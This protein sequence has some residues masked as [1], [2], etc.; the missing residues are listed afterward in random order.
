MPR[1]NYNKELKQLRAEFK[2]IFNCEL[3]YHLFY[4]ALKNTILIDYPWTKSIFEKPRENLEERF[5]YNGHNGEIRWLMDNL[6]D[7]FN[8]DIT[9]ISRFMQL[10]KLPL[11]DFFQL[12]IDGYEYADLK[13]HESFIDFLS[14]LE[15]PYSPENNDFSYLFKDN[16]KYAFD[17]FHNIFDR[18]I[19]EGLVLALDKESG[20]VFTGY[21][22]QLINELEEFYFFLTES[23]FGTKEFS[24]KSKGTGNKLK[25][26]SEELQYLF[27]QRTDL[28]NKRWMPLF[29]ITNSKQDLFLAFTKYILEYLKIILKFPG[30]PEAI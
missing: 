25:V 10:N 17:I 13:T 5:Y 19:L 20:A 14:F 6:T 29:S 21:V 22:R 24:I 28:I 27:N 4:E 16:R 26:R 15:D 1:R 30:I 23:E 9:V 11:R 3:N 8:K 18:D 12:Y 2:A 7:K